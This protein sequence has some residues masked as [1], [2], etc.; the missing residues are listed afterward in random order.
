M[1]KR[2]FRT[3]I[4]GLLGLSVVLAAAPTATAETGRPHRV[5]IIE[6]DGAQHTITLD[7]SSLEFLSQEDGGETVVAFDLAALG[8]VIDEAVAGALAGLDGALA[9]LDDFDVRVEDDVLAIRQGDD[10]TRVDLEDLGRRID[11]ARQE[12]R[13][14]LAH[15]GIVIG[16]ARDRTGEAADLRAEIAALQAEL[17]QLRADLEARGD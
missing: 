5:I 16:D 17:T 1:C 6:D 14:E 9:A 3:A 10:V 4:V 12:M 7:G 8:P 11:I 13:R 15:E 2:V